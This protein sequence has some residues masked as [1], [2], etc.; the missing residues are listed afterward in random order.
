VLSLVAASSK[1]CGVTVVSIFLNPMQFGTNE[2]LSAYPRDFARDERLCREAGVAVVFA[3][4][5]AEIY[6]AGFQTHVEPGDLAEPLC[7]V[8]RPGHFR[9]VATVVTKLFN[10][11]QPDLAFFGQKDLQQCA[12][13][14]RMVADLNLPLKSSRWRPSAKPTASR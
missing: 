11:A 6:P 12:V 7:G 4:D 2:D 9:G 10:I 13:V 1:R 5:V 3:P 14:R 8:F